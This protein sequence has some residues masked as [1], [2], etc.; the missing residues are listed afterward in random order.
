MHVSFATCV[1]H[2]CVHAYGLTI[3]AV[4]TFIYIV[5]TGIQVVMHSN[6]I[7]L[8]NCICILVI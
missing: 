8:Y 3:C 5:Y 4:L 2:A 6:Y 1:F 7:H